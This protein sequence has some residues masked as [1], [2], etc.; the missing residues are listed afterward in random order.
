MNTRLYYLCLIVLL[1]FKTDP[2]HLE[3]LKMMFET[4]RKAKHAY[5]V[6]AVLGLILC[7][8]LLLLSACSVGLSSAS[9]ETM[10]SS[11]APSDTTAPASPSSG[12]SDEENIEASK[13]LVEGF[14]KVLKNVSL[15]APSDDIAKS[16]DDNYAQYVTPGLLTAWKADPSAAPGRLTSSPWPDRIEILSVEKSAAGDY[17]LSGKIIEVTS[18]EVQNGGAAATRPFNAVVIL[19][20]KGMLISEWNFIVTDDT[21]VYS[22]TDYGFDFRLPSNW[23]GYAIL[24]DMWQGSPLTE[25]LDLLNSGPKLII[26]SP[27]WTSDNPIYDIPIMVFTVAQW[28]AVQKEQLAVSAAPVPPTELDRNDSYIFALPP[29]YDF[30]DLPG[31]ADVTAILSGNPLTA[32][33]NIGILPTDVSGFKISYNNTQFGFSFDL[34]ITWAGYTVVYESWSG[35]PL[36]EVVKPES[37]LALLLRNPK[38]TA[39]NPTQDIPIMV[40]SIDQWNALQGE[41][42]SV[43]AAPIPP[44]ELGRNSNYIFA[45]PARYNYAYLPGYEEVDVLITGNPL[46]AY[47]S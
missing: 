10:T 38:W 21:V 16:M 28:E 23:N 44:S 35:T 36:T 43:S 30:Y 11:A 24:A 46:H 15:L 7:L 31:L 27:Q 6:S 5:V 14:G 18:T 45:L 47:T 42:F 8:G 39:E 4:K 20:D 29:R 1:V 26:R 9:P 17:A 37:G 22:N 34:P 13:A 19:T 40:F 25:G 12:N 2:V 41:N 33:E 3:R 32:T